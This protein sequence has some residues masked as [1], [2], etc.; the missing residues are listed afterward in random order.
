MRGPFHC[1]GPLPLTLSS[2]PL[3][4]PLWLFLSPPVPTSSAPSCPSSDTPA[5]TTLPPLAHLPPPDP[6]PP[7]RPSRCE[8]VCCPHL[9]HR[10]QPTYPAHPCK[11]AAP[12]SIPSPSPNFPRSIANVCVEDAPCSCNLTRVCMDVHVCVADAVVCFAGGAPSLCWPQARYPWPC[13]RHVGPHAIPGLLL[14]PGMVWG[15]GV[16][17]GEGGLMLALRGGWGR[18]VCCCVVGGRVA[19]WLGGWAV[20]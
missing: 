20:G 17:G 3:P 13:R 7:R 18:M 16:C 11:H 5:C 9:V 10:P 4:L 14:L 1:N 2:P 12:P 6:H 19:G 15:Y 8:A